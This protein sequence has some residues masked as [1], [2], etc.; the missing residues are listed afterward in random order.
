MTPLLFIG[1]FLSYWSFNLSIDVSIQKKGILIN[2]PKNVDV[3]I[4]SFSFWSFYPYVSCYFLSANYLEWGNRADISSCMVM[5]ATT[6]ERILQVEAVQIGDWKNDAQPKS[7][8]LYFIQ[9][10]YQGLYPGKR[11]LR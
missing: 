3:Q 11:L 7:W 1:L 6:L 8:E 4:S 2:L 9:G 5:Y 10:P